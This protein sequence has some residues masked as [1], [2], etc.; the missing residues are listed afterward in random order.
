[1]RRDNHYYLLIKYYILSM[2]NNKLAPAQ[3]ARTIYNILF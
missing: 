2:P 3:Y 1:M